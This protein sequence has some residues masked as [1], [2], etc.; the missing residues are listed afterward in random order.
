M[1]DL[2]ASFNP[3]WFRALLVSCVVSAG[4][5]MATSGCGDPR[6]DA[7]GPAV[8]RQQLASPTGPIP[9]AT[10]M[11][12]ATLLADGRVLVAGGV[13][14]SG[15][16]DVASNSAL[17][18]DP[19]TN[20]WSVTGN[21]AT[22]RF[23]AAAIRLSDGRVLISGGGSITGSEYASNEVYDPATGT[24]SAPFGNLMVPRWRPSAVLL[25]NGLVM[26]AGGATGSTDAQRAEIV[27]GGFIWNWV[28]PYH[29]LVTL[30]RVSNHTILALFDNQG[31]LFDENTFSWTTT[32][33]PLTPRA[34]QKAIGLEDGR[35]LMLGG[36][37]SVPLP[38]GTFTNAP[39]ELVELY[40]PATG[41]WSATGSLSRPPSDSDRLVSV[42]GAGVLLIGSKLRVERYSV[43]TGTWTVL[44]PLSKPP[45]TATALASGTVLV[46][47]AA[48]AYDYFTAAEIYDPASP[49]CTATTC[50]AKA[51]QCG[52]TDNGCGD[53]LLCGSCGT[54]QFCNAGI[55]TCS[56]LTTCAAQ[57]K[58]CGSISDGCG[59]TLNCGTCAPGQTCTNNVC[60]AVCV[61]TTC[62]AQGRS[63]GTASDGCG[64]TL[65]CG[66]C[67]PG[68]ACSIAGV[69]TTPPPS[70][71]VHSECIAGM[72]LTTTCSSCA[73]KV[74]S[75]DSYCCNVSWDS[76]CVSEAKSMC[77][78]C[79]GATCTPTTCSAQGKNCGSIS[80]GC[81]GTLSCGTCATGQT[82]TNNVCTGSSPPSGSCAHS[83][84]TTG[85]KLTSGCTACVGSICGVDPYCC[86][87]G[88]DSI[89]VGEVSSVCKLGCP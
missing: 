48:Y 27:G 36:Q 56:S 51:V 64:G 35:V 53:V 62:T 60:V 10:S 82:C 66:T 38:N 12:T 76:L 9:G 59:G 24:F 22:A 37:I 65:N 1:E 6:G 3:P 55:C 5:A 40:D 21:L 49:S 25:S 45:L 78:S 85:A 54:G 42:P 32:G 43:A 83:Q 68:Q 8:V 52:A 11:D 87:T 50:A 46:T 67:A 47:E 80:N 86:N 88:W 17:L 70:N 63:C 14:K 44:D 19:V 79:G 2:L 58:N 26:V 7:R 71:C 20:Q 39:T 84:C 16:D 61:P 15:G 41:T 77:S 89:C 30:T 81:G 33:S 57:N 13:T 4:A 72:K 18:F 23:G 75:T 73:Q 69:C 31:W 29:G 74:C 34:G 28:G